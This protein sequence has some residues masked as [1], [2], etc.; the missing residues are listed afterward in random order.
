MNRVAMELTTSS[1]SS[2]CQGNLRS[3]TGIH[4]S[5]LLLVIALVIELACHWAD[6][7]SFHAHLVFVTVIRNHS[8]HHQSIAIRSVSPAAWIMIMEFHGTRHKIL[9][10][11]GVWQ[12]L[13][14]HK[15]LTRSNHFGV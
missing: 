8:H 12:H 9:R 4:I 7:V 10:Q 14:V 11:A 2:F 5:R 6:H 15:R 13:C 1:L 3:I